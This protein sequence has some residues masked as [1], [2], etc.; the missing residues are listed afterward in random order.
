MTID[1]D[2][3]ERLIELCYKL[4]GALKV[5][6]RHGD[7]VS[8]KIVDMCMRDLNEAYGYGAQADAEE[9]I[10]AVQEEHARAAEEQ[11]AS[12]GKLHTVKRQEAEEPQ[13]EP[14]TDAATDAIE[15]GAGEADNVIAEAQ[16]EEQ[17]D[18]PEVSR[19]VAGIKVKPEAVSESAATPQAPVSIN[20]LLADKPGELR[21]DEALSRREARNLRKA[22]TLN[23]KFRFRRE[24]FKGDDRLFG[25]TLDDIQHL[26]SYDDALAY[27]EEALGWKLDNEE[28]ADFM[29]VVKN[30]FDSI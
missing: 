7:D 12:D 9:S 20:E 17:D 16:L 15:R 13:V 26:S 24:L 14:E 28:V 10:R 18:V 1:M 25:Q 5:A 3:I 19:E 30:H 11:Y 23:D 27:V 2:N 8:A 22:F 4:E 21:L 6:A 29:L